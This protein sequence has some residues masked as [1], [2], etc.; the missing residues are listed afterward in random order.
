MN[1]FEYVLE[2][3]LLQFVNRVMCHVKTKKDDN[4]EK[5]DL[6]NKQLPWWYSNKQTKKVSWSIKKTVFYVSLL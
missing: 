4:R 6:I 5:C 2:F 3:D 1:S